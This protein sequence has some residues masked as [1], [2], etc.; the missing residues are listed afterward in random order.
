MKTVFTLLSVGV[1]HSWHDEG[2]PM[3]IYCGMIGRR[4]VFCGER[5]PWWARL[6]CR[7]RLG[8]INVETNA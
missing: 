1:D 7:L 6:L 2:S 3:V 5:F 8:I 4:V